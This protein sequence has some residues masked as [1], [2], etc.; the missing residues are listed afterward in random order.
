MKY[1]NH[2]HVLLE[3]SDFVTLLTLLLFSTQQMNKTQYWYSHSFSRPTAKRQEPTQTAQD[4]KTTK[5]ILIL[6]NICYVCRQ[7]Q[8]A[9]ARHASLANC[10]IGR[11]LSNCVLCPNLENKIEDM[12]GYKNLSGSIII[13]IF[14]IEIIGM[15]IKFTRT[16]VCCQIS[17]VIQGDKCYSDQWWIIHK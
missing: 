2:L 13:I 12:W 15:F 5:S 16:I 6:Y 7:E 4:A 11:L 10:K 17:A 8:E 9:S 14:F 1:Y 3:D